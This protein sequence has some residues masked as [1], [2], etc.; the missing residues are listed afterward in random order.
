[1]I[2]IREAQ[3]NDALA[4]AKVHVD[5]RKDTYN[6]I[7]PDSYLS[8]RTYETATKNWTNR[9]GN[10]QSNEL[11]FV[12]ENNEGDLVG[13]TSASTISGDDSFEG[14]LSTLYISKYHQR[15]GIG[16]L[17]VQAA[18]KKLI[19]KNIKSLMVW[20]YAENP[21]RNFY[22]RLGGRPVKEKIVNR[23]KKVSEVAYGWDDITK[24][25]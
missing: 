23:G 1:M 17:L 8:K 13:F 2:S 3:I 16:Q 5:T 7:I 9:I 19:E 11:I 6:G 10:P 22:E 12:A 14:L 18:I 24:L 21:S 20:V 25:V 4:I 15:Q